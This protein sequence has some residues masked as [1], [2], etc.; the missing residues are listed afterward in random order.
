M[1]QLCPP[2]VTHL[3]T[4]RYDSRNSVLEWSILLVDNS[5]RRSEIFLNLFVFK[6]CFIVLFSFLLFYWPFQWIIF[7]WTLCSGSMEFVVPP[8]DS[9]LFFPISV[10]FSATSTFSDLKVC[11]LLSFSKLWSCFFDECFYMK[12]PF[13]CFSC[14]CYYQ[15]L[16]ES[17][18]ILYIFFLMWARKTVEL[19]WR[20]N[21][22][23]E[24]N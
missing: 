20:F 18:S 16:F 6:T 7:C 1:Y 24:E 21:L 5:N 10:R 22:V 14:Q 2:S 4:C 23:A 15:R 19:L 3:L 11:T 12:L 13:C 8:V 9:S 17:F